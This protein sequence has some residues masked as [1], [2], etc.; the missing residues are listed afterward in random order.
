M[1][2]L[3]RTSPVLA[4]L[5]LSSCATPAT[6]T[7]RD[8]EILSWNI[9]H[10]ANAKGELNLAEKRD[11]LRESSA[12]LIFL[13][14]IDKVCERSGDVDQML[15]LAE[16]SDL[17]PGFGAFMPYQGGEY[18]LGTLSRLPVAHYHSLRLPDGNEPRVALILET[19]ILDRSLIAANVH[20]NWIR[21]DT[22]CV[23]DD[24]LGLGVQITPVPSVST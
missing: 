12:D 20:F 17:V 9:L 18:G 13:Q 5:V 10:G 8:L 21:D 22:G 2:T 15:Y 19:T 14:E 3:F 7:T 1:V 23:E 6:P 16:D 24:R 4:I 11:Y